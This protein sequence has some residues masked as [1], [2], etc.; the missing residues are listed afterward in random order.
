[1]NY[2]M[3][4]D[5]AVIVLEWPGSDLSNRTHHQ[6]PCPWKNQYYH[7]FNSSFFMILPIHPRK[8]AQSSLI[9]KNNDTDLLES[10]SYPEL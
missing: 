3:I 5:V 4:S 9:I 6:V 7:P 8:K 2:K 1:M 10:S